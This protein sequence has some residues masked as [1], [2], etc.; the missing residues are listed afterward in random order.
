MATEADRDV[1][2]EDTVRLTIEVGGGLE[3]EVARARKMTTQAA[4]AQQTAAAEARRVA[5][6]LRSTGLSVADTA[7]I[8]DI[9]KG[10]VSQL[11]G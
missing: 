3:D 4:Q 8:M 9:N 6:R 7:A 11:T 10:R 2:P 1:D 5:R